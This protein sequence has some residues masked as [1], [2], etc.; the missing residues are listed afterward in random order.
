MDSPS[1][2]TSPAVTTSEHQSALDF[3][4]QLIRDLDSRVPASDWH[5]SDVTPVPQVNH[6]RKKPVRFRISKEVIPMTPSESEAPST[7]V[8][9]PSIHEPT[10][11]T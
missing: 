6:P 8:I 7:E 9:Q 10:V 11:V 5:M 4:A 3:S 1:S 2:P